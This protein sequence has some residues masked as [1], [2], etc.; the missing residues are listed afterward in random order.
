MPGAFRSIKMW[1]R[2]WCL[3]DS[4]ELTFHLTPLVPVNIRPVT[5][6][7]LVP[8]QKMCHQRPP[9]EGGFSPGCKL[10]QVVTAPKKIPPTLPLLSRLEF[11][12]NRD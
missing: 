4:R 10:V 12:T 11:P 7:A 2:T 9:R 3:M 1:G 5:K 6:I 8:G